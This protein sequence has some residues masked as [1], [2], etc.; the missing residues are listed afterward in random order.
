M[1]NQYINVQNQVFPGGAGGTLGNIVSGPPVSTNN[2]LALWSGTAGN[3]LQN[4]V[5]TVDPSGNAAGFGTI[6]AASGGTNTFAG[7]IAVG[8]L[9]ANV[10]GA[11]GTFLTVSSSAHT[12]NLELQYAAGTN[13]TGTDLGLIRVYNGT[14]LVA[15]FRWQSDN[16]VNNSGTF[17]LQMANAGSLGTALT[18][19]YA[20]S[21]A[22]GAL[23]ALSTT[24][25]AG[26]LYIP[27][28]AGAPSGTPASFT[29]KTA[30]VYDTTDNKLY[31]YNGAWKSTTLA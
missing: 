12:A 24:A 28:C 23:S 14:N 5:V 18:A 4:S 6:A 27:S 8:G 19:N 13:S 22:I 31:V 15:F 29:G 30:M 26:F 11:S 7:N 1:A 17:L 9:T 25:T 3:Q 21:V 16:G 10:S 2:A 20:G